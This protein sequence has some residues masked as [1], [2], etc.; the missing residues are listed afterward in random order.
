[1]PDNVEKSQT[2]LLKIN[3]A[4]FIAGMLIISRS[5]FYQ[6]VNAV[7]ST[8]AILLLLLS[9]GGQLFRVTAKQNVLAVDKSENDDKGQN[10]VHQSI[11][12]FSSAGSTVQHLLHLIN[13]EYPLKTKITLALKQLPEFFGDCRFLY[14]AVEEDQIRFIAGSKKNN[15]NLCEEIKETDS[16]V[17]DASRKIH[18]CVDIRAIKKPWGFTEPMVFDNT[19]SKEQGLLIPVTF[20]GQLYGI[21]VATGSLAPG[22]SLT[23]KSLLVDFSHGLA[24]LLENHGLFFENRSKNEAA[25]EDK[26]ADSLFARLLP[27][28]P[29][30][31]RGWD[32]S[33]TA[34]YADE[35][36]G[37]F[38]LFLNMPGDRTMLLI[39]KCSG[40]GLKAALFLVKLHTMVSCLID[41][42]QTPADLLNQV[43]KLMTLENLT[44]L[45]ATAAALQIRA[46]DRAVQLAMAGHATPLINRTRSGYVEVPQL[47]S[48]V[49][50][51]LFNQ[52][53]EPYKNQ[54]IQ[55]LPGDGILFYTEGVT[56]FPAYGR[57]RIS[58][59]EL[60]QMLD[61]LPEES[62]KVMLE[63][64]VRQLS[65]GKPALRP[66]EDHTL[67]YAKSE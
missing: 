7:L 13:P 63:N 47:D 33:Q 56:E 8:T 28:Q 15:R 61:K 14:F 20:F 60:R 19:S 32:I 26:L 11:L 24:L 30:Q 39:G 31:L 64:L 44:E 55:L 23:Q 6:D 5:V 35:H 57:E 65:S 49:P 46:G 12:P 51:G 38:H 59:E 9:F 43:S 21:M 54:T 45:F 67:I 50:L 29:P 58:L 34:N 62:A 16:L 52:G 22:F 3:I 1:M 48:G 2:L 18:N 4:V 10:D 40:K 53:L 25:A 36:S 27:L 37:D 17:D 66:V 42:C 41:Q